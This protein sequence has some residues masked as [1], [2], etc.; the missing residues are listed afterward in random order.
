MY[1]AYG[2]RSG[3]ELLFDT[4]FSACMQMRSYSFPYP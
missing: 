3:S 4:N 1:L 2:K